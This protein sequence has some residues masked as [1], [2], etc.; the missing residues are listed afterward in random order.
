MSRSKEYCFNGGQI[1][2]FCTTSLE[3]YKE[4]YQEYEWGQKKSSLIIFFSLLGGFVLMGVCIWI[5]FEFSKKRARQKINKWACSQVPS[6]NRILRRLPESEN[7]PLQRLTSA[8]E[9]LMTAAR[10]PLPTRTNPPQDD[11]PFQSWNSQPYTNDISREQPQALDITDN[12]PPERPTSS[13]RKPLTA[14][15]IQLPPPAQIPRP[16]P[17]IPTQETQ[18]QSS[19]IDREES[20]GP[21]NGPLQHWTSAQERLLTAA[22][23]PLP[24]RLSLLNLSN[25]LPGAP[26]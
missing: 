16:E 8:Q 1:D 23:I 11:W 19:S 26:V 10:I 9:R 13:Q 7:V 18:P 15:G 24:L 3:E 14:A 25:R 5:C 17:Q 21:H 20:H 22:G 6:N 2:E 4:K 12:I